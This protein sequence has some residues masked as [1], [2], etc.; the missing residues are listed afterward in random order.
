[1]NLMSSRFGHDF[2]HVRVHSDA[3]AAKS[4]QAVHALAYTVGSHVV[5]GPDQYSPGTTRGQH[6]LAHELTHVLQQK[7]AAGAAHAASQA[8]NASAE[9]SADAAADAVVAGRAVGVVGGTSPG[10]YRK[11]EPYIKKVTVHLSPP[12]SAELEWKGTAPADAPGKDSFTVSTG[13]GY[14]DPDDP[15]GTC[16]RQ[17]CGDAEK[18]C[19]PP[20]NQPS[21]VGACCT[22]YGNDFWTGVPQADHGGWK[23]WTPIQPHYSKRTIALHQHPEVTGKPIGHGCVRMDEANAERIYTYSRGR[24]TNVTI[25]GRASPVA[26][27]EDRKCPPP[28]TRSKKGGGRQGALEPAAE[29]EET[30]LASAEP[31]T[32]E[33]AGEQEAPVVPGLEGEMS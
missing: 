2:S 6:L 3:T 22:F 11:D 1:M 25:D 17:C 31:A 27:A 29:D 18:Q 15:P 28:R 32:E 7:S 30:Q 10:L 16:T 33:L 4:A 24:K 12:Q 5:F 8:P 14:G 26:C 21:K 23:F 19:A 13:K 9:A 20:W